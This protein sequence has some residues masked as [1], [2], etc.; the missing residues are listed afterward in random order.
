MHRYKH[1]QTNIQTHRSTQTHACR[2]TVPITIQIPYSSDVKSQD[3][4]FPLP[5][6]NLLL[7]FST[8]EK[9]KKRDNYVALFSVG[10][11]PLDGEYMCGHY[12]HTLF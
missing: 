3:V 10:I 11:V 4:E 9:L 8:C 2:Y 7:S 1:R 12:Y 5:M 6:R